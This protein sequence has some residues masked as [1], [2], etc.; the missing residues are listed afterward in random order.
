[1]T[2]LDTIE[3]NTSTDFIKSLKIECFNEVSTS[4][5]TGE[6]TIKYHL[7]T[8]TIGLKGIT[9]NKNL[10]TVRINASSK[11]LGINYNKG[12]NINTIEQFIDEIGNNGLILNKD[13]LNNLYL[14]RIDVKNDLHFN[15]DVKLY[16]N[17]LNQLIAFKFIKTSY[18]NGIVFKENI[19]TSPIYYTGY[20]K[21]HELK[22]NIKF[23][24]QYPSMA[25][26]FSNTLRIETK[27]KGVNAIKK[28]FKTKNILDIL[29]F[30]DFNLNLLDKIIDKQTKFKPFISTE[31][32]TNTQEKNFAQI[33]YLN[34]YYNG[35]FNKII[36]HIKSKLGE[37]TKAS[38][39]RGQVKKYLSMLNNDNKDFLHYLEEIK[40]KLKE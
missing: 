35:D 2:C 34:E 9:I 5:P 6:K 4:T 40:D 28:H 12:I 13:F 14:K 36:N 31:N 3:F 22:N 30:S 11:L 20:S 33:Y 24:K 32:M 15:K 29:S 7:K 16:I 10:Q 18:P 1:M 21:I 8:K 26:F 17:T 37:K 19:K 38:Y 27:L 39:Q 25:T 23:L